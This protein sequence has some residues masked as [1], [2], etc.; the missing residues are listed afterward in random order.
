[1]KDSE[2]HDHIYKYIYVW[3]S[4]NH[5]WL[6][7]THRLYSP[8]N[9]PGQN[10]GAFPFSRESSQPGIEPRSPTLE[11][12][13]YQLS[14]KIW[15]EEPGGLP[16]MGSHRVGHDW[17]DLAAAE[18]KMHNAFRGATL[19]LIAGFSTGMIWYRRQQSTIFKVLEQIKT[20]SLGFYIWWW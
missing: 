18:G 7:A 3:K 19:R 5:V 4:F 16:S 20:S 14:H 17:S 13:L 10:T 9:S 6:F 15:T 1:M 12:I 11:A 8:W 2:V